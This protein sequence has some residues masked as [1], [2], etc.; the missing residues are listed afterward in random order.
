M[1]IDLD[2]SQKKHI[3]YDQHQNHQKSPLSS[4]SRTSSKDCQKKSLSPSEGPAIWKLESLL[5]PIKGA[6][7]IGIF[8]P[9]TLFLALLMEF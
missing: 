4:P 6:F 5:K 1:E 3:S 7:Q 9:I 8:G 2:N